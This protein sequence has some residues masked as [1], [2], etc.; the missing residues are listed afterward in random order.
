MSVFIDGV[1]ERDD[2][3]AEDQLRNICAAER[4][5]LCAKR[6]HLAL[7]VSIDKQETTFVE[8]EISV[9][10]SRRHF[11]DEEGEKHVIPLSLSVSSL[12]PERFYL[13]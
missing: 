5:S 10:V 9:V 6:R 2:V 1:V 8:I 12:D 7:L 11:S 3:L 13:L 4:T